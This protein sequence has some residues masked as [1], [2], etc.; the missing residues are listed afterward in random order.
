MRLR[1]GLEKEDVELAEK[2]LQFFLYPQFELHERKKY[3]KL[4]S[5]KD[6]QYIVE[7]EIHPAV[8]IFELIDLLKKNVMISAFVN[9]AGGPGL[10][11]TIKIAKSILQLCN[12]DFKRLG[13][14]NFVERTRAR[15]VDKLGFEHVLYEFEL[16]SKI[17]ELGK[18]VVFEDETEKK[19]PDLQVKNSN[20]IF[21]ECK[22]LDGPKLYFSKICADVLSIL[23]NPNRNVRIEIFPEDYP[24]ASKADIIFWKY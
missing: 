18:N 20:T 16:A 12:N 22:S 21:F 24:D 1:C 5:R 3:K 7:I 8:V 17:S 13:G 15:F 23:D 10:L 9:S 14:K 19:W 2:F 6:F 4:Q 11:L